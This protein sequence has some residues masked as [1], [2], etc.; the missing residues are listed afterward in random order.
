MKKH[1]L[2]VDDDLALTETISRSLQ[3]NGYMVTTTNSGKEAFTFLEIHRFDLILCDIHMDEKDGFAILAASDTMSPKPQV[4]LCSD[5]VVYKTIS[6]AFK[7]GAASF[8]AK[9]FLTSELRHQ[10][11][12]C[13][14]QKPMLP[15]Q[16][17]T[18]KT[19]A[20]KLFGDDGRFGGQSSPT[21]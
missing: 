20:T 16:K 1:I 2:V 4:I 7:C 17:M 9:P 21:N 10:V 5:D 11:D 14:G 3:A 6:L 8:L 13:L 19:V 15:S 12:R 18:P